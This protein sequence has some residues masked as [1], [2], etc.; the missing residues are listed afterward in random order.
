MLLDIGLPG[1]DGYEIA[2]CLRSSGLTD[3][4]LVALTGYGQDEDRRRALDAG[5]DLH[6]TK[7]V[8]PKELETALLARSQS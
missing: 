8:D 2:R 6:M 4:M 1:T 5:F 3:P 7:P